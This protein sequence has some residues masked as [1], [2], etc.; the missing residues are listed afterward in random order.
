MGTYFET[1]LVHV[2]SLRCSS[3]FSFSLT[4]AEKFAEFEFRTAEGSGSNLGQE[5]G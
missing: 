2:P 4:N 3:F 1:R 5:A